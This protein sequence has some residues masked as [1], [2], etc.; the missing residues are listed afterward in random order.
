MTTQYF[1][2]RIFLN[3]QMGELVFKPK[4]DV[5]INAFELIKEQKRNEF[6]DYGRE[7]ILYYIKGLGRDIHIMQLARKHVYTKPI[8]G[9]RKIEEVS[10]VDYPNIYLIFHVKY[11]I[12]LIQ[13]DTSVFQD[14]DAVKGK[15]QRFLVDKMGNYGV[16]AS[17]IEITDQRDFW[18]KLD[19]IDFIDTV[20]LEYAPP[21]FFGGKN[22]VDKITKEVQEETN[23]EKFKIILQNKY[24]GLKFGYDTFKE[25]IQRLSSGAGDFVIKGL[26][27][28]VPKTL[29][30]FIIPF[31]KDITDPEEETRESLEETFEEINDMNKDANR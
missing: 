17:L 19:E 10:D 21:N 15:I 23:Y 1:A 26:K 5:F 29:K 7:H 20:E 25:H 27:D 6:Q 14:L 9:E 12:V 18:T 3:Q 13:K 28:G 2:Y 11:Q 4:E 22:S 8:A 24:E 31:K 30:K 16:V